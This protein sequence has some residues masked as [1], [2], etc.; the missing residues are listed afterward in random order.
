MYELVLRESLKLYISNKYLIISLVLKSKMANQYTYGKEG[1]YEKHSILEQHEL[2]LK[3]KEYQEVYQ[4]EVEALKGKTHWDNKRKRHVQ[5][6]P[7]LGYITK[8]VRTF[9]SNLKDVKSDSPQIKNAC[10]LAKRCLDKLKNGEFEDGVAKKKFRS[11]GGGRKYRAVEVREALFAWFIDVRSSLKARLPKSL[12]LIQAKKLYGEWLQHH[13]ETSEEEQLKFSNCWVKDWEL[14]YGVSLRKPN[15]RYSISKED[16]VTR[17]QDYLKNIWSVRYYFI[18][19]FGVDPPIINGDQMPLHRNESSG[20]ATLNFKN[21]DTFVKENHM[22]SRERITVFTQISNDE[23]VKLVPEFVFKGSGKRP[24][25]LTTPSGSHYQWALKGSYRL[26]QLLETIKH[27]P[28][29]FNI[30]SHSNY[31]IYVLDDYAVHLMPEVRQA[32]WNRGYILVIIGGGIT[33]F[34]QVNDTHLHHLLK[35]KYR[36]RESELMLEKLQ[37]NPLKVPIPDRNE[38]MR[39]LVAADKDVEFDVK[40]AFKSV[41]VTNALDGA[42]DYHVSDKIFSLVGES[43]KNYRS[44]MMSTPPPK[45]IK[46]VI[47]ALIPPKG[48]KRGRNIEGIELFDGEEIEEEDEV[49]EDAEGEV[50]EEVAI[51]DLLAALDGDIAIETVVEEPVRESNT[52]TGNTVSLVGISENEDINKDAR[53]LDEISKIFNSYETSTQFTSARNQIEVA[54]QSARR[55]LKKRIRNEEH[56]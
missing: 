14:E 20:Q 50:G 3:V 24:P 37:N 8:A 31:A 22:L 35:G 32:L 25:E 51:D 44:K 28:N 49:E 18:K 45:T 43:M 47:N 17:V 1:T 38:I 11:V 23:N 56:Q 39:L 6:V 4:A 33:G 9:Y 30:F 54:Y 42:E 29:R 2:A 27:L 19:T 55:S 34:V 52:V 10:K 26:E 16:C 53:F 15:K 7:K 5:D 41:W 46:A 21:S 36:K 40:L 13:P 12:F 48:I